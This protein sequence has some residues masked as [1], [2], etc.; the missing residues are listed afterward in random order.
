MRRII[1]HLRNKPEQTRRDILHLATVAFAVILVTL[2]FYSL[3]ENFLN[4][5]TQRKIEQ[6]L[7]P[8]SVLKDNIVGG[9]K[10]I[11]SPDLNVQQ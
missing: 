6:D 11:S 7:K 3:G 1:H 4:S 5:D 8:F 9:Y 10:S 2:W